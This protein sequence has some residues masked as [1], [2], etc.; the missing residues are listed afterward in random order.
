MES[1]MKV[2]GRNNYKLQHIRKEK[3]RREGRLPIAITYS[4]EALEIANSYLNRDTECVIGN[5]L[6]VLEEVVDSMSHMFLSE[7]DAIFATDNDLKPL[8]LNCHI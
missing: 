1:A 3:L 8:Q 4:N 2:G 6:D 5:V 7:L